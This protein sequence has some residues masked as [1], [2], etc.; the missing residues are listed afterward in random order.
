MESKKIK[1]GDFVELEYTGKQKDE[2]IVFD[3]T[4]KEIAIANDLNKEADYKP[5]VICIG[6]GI[7]LPVLEEGLVGK[8]PGKY[9]FDLDPEQAFGKKSAQLLKLIPMKV[10]KQQDIMPYV[11]LDVNIDNQYGIIRNVSGGRVI[12]DF[13]HP[14]SGRDL[15]YDIEVKKFVTNDK[16]KLDSLLKASGIHYDSCS[17]KEKN[18]MIVLEHDVPDEVKKIVEDKVKKLVNIKKFSYVTKKKDEKQQ[19]S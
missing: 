8:K 5:V 9:T 13:N 19:K 6:E 12:V 4:V 14:L 1:K 15:T 11:G 7:M 18:A 3:T 10:F 16:E 17:V 2:G